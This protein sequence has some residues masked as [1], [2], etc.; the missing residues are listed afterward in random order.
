MVIALRTPF[1]GQMDEAAFRKALDETLAVNPLL[2]SVVDTSGWQLKWK[3]CAGPLSVLTCDHFEGEYPPLN[4]PPQWIDLSQQVGLVLN[5]RLAPERGVLISYFHHACVDGLGAIRFL[6]DVFARYGELTARDGQEKPRVRQP[7]P[8]VLLRRGSTK[9]PGRCRD[10]RAPV[11]HTLKET[12]RLLCRKSYRILGYSPSLRKPMAEDPEQDVSNILHTEVLP[13]VILKQ[14]KKMAA[15]KG[16]STNDVCMM[17]FLQQI[18]EWSAEDPSSRDKDLFRIL[19]PVS[20]RTPQHDEISAANVVSYVFHSY[21]RHEIQDADSLLSA[22]HSKSYQMINR[23][24]GAAMLFGFAA[25][26]WIPGVFK[27]SRQLQPDFASVVMTNVGE[28][29]RVFENRFPLKQGRAVAGNVV[30]QRIDGI[31][32]VRRNTNISIAFGTYGGEFI[33]HLN[34]NTKMFSQAEADELLATLVDRLVA[35]VRTSMV[36]ELRDVTA[37]AAEYQTAPRSKPRTD[38]RVVAGAGSAVAAGR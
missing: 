38:S 20:M 1:E 33:V 24:E 3:P 36:D 30:I 8:T 4:C 2:C 14:L 32:P 22:I 31:A 27:L 11:W 29:R 19:M 28:V 16:V 5:L 6:G 15:A 26:R 7:D 37:I 13:R 35:L 9:M 23:N 12:F 10:R 17:V 18:A 21:R 34:R 25:T